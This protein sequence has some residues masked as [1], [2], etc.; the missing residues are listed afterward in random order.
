MTDPCSWTLLFRKHRITVLL[1]LLPSE[2]IP[3]TKQALLKALQARGL[4]DIN[5]DTV[6]AD[7]SEIELGVAVDKNDLDKGWTSLE[8]LQLDDD[9]APKRGGANKAATLSLKAADI[10]NGQSIA[11]RFRKPRAEDSVDLELEDP[12]WD[13]ILPRLEDDEEEP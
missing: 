11:F 1:M 9:E 4:E 2:T 5:G 3:N 8:A 6:P 12:G 7:P 13:V 10:N